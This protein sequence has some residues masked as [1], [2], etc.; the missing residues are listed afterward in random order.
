MVIDTVWQIIERPVDVVVLAEL[1]KLMN[2]NFFILVKRLVDA[3]YAAVEKHNQLWVK[4]EIFFY[5]QMNS[6]PSGEGQGEEKV[7]FCL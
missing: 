4:M 5:F 3:D 1:V 2:Y 7:I 6:S